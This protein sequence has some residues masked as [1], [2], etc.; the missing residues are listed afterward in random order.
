MEWNEKL[1]I[2]LH[3]F[4]P[5][6]AEELYLSLGKDTS[7]YNSPWPEYDDFMLIDDDVTIAIQI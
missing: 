5:H 2:M 4:A 3:P 6:M 1:A 7:I